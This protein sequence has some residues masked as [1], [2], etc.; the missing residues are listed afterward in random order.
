[1]KK[2]LTLLACVLMAIGVG[3]IF[4]AC[5]NGDSGA[6]SITNLTYNGEQI[7]WSSVKNAKNYKININNGTESIVSQAE[8]TVSYRYNSNGEDFDFS[9]EAVIK[10]GSDKN[11]TYSIRFENIG[12]VTGL[13]IEQGNLTWNTLDT[14]EKYEIMYNGNIVSSAVGT[15]S[16]P[17]T[18]GSFS[19]KVRA[20]KGQAE[21]S[22]GNI[23]YYSL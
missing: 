19:Y 13:A 17:A 16:Y 9:I 14:A 12:Q 21:S 5:S 20:L 7:T 18:S 3:V 10:E 6:K 4:A 22:D 15:N 2:L 8:G 11:P 23:P 1:M